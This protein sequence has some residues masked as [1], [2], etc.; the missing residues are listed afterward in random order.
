MITKPHNLRVAFIGLGLMGR[1][2]AECLVQAGFNVA[3]YNRNPA[4]AAA[5]AGRA[6]VATTPRGA[7]QGAEFVI[8]MVADDAAARAVW[9]G[10]D[11]ALAGLAAGAVCIESSTVSPAWIRELGE[12]ARARGAECLDA[13]VTGSRMQAMSGQL[14]FVVGGAAAAIERAR[15]LF[16]A[17]GA[18]L[19]PLGPLGSGALFKLINNFLCGAQLAALAEAMA[20]IDRSGLDRT[21]AVA[22]LMAGATGSPLAKTVSARMLAADYTPNFRVQ[23]MAKDLDYATVLAQSMGVNLTMGRSAHASFS[24]AAEAGYG[25]QDIAAIYPAVASRGQAH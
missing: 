17:M 13:P 24:A 19:A 2:M 5:F 1:G 11:G 12:A 9:L 18:S 16:A 20:L 21:A 14:G 4:N 23:L 7:A 22:T 6:A 25:N 8:S 10:P 15:P 3:V